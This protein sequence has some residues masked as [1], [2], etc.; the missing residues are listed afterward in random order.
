MSF[1]VSVSTDLG[2]KLLNNSLVAHHVGWLMCAAA[3][4]A[5]HHGGRRATAATVVGVCFI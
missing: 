4:G 3:L 2:V 1:F 5:G